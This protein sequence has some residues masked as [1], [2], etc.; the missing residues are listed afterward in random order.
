MRF[1]FSLIVCFFYF[2]LEAA[3]ISCGLAR[4]SQI[5]RAAFRPIG[6]FYLK[7]PE[8]QRALVTTL[9]PHGAS[10]LVQFFLF[11]GCSNLFPFL[12]WLVQTYPQ[13]NR[14]SPFFLRSLHGGIFKALHKSTSALIGR[15]LLVLL[16]RCHR[17][18]RLRTALRHILIEHSPPT[19]KEGRECM[20]SAKKCR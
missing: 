4:P 7:H 16:C 10:T 2:L 5:G 1:A 3:L 20:A 9:F 17:F 6:A 14:F 13:Q 15:G 12:P 18:A 19:D 8:I 11:I